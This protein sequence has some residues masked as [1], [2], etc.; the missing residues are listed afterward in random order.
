MLDRES[1]VRICIDDF[2]LKRRYRYG[3]VM[4][5][6]DT[7]QIIDM[8][9]SREKDDVAKWLA[10]YPRINVVSRD[11]SQQY[12]AAIRQAHPDAIQVS[13]R[14][15]ILQNLTDSAKQHIS[16][17]VAANFRIPSEE[18]AVGVGGG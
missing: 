17:V 3:T 8:I 16:K 5:N 14:F 4:V 6:I 18:G 10:T 1:V 7:G 12:A 9:E 15:H 13:D 11:G 2:A